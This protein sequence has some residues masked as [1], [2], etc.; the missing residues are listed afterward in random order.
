MASTE[1]AAAAERKWAA[2]RR[3][4]ERNG[5]AEITLTEQEVTGRANLWASDRKLPVADLRVY[6]CRPDDEHP[7]GQGQVTSASWPDEH[8]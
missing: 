4:L 5:R 8:G 7:Q 3:T 1:G 6:F 2:F